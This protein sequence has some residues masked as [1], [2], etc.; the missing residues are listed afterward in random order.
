MDVTANFYPVRKMTSQTTTEKQQQGFFDIGM[1]E[2]FWC[3]GLR[4]PPIN[5]WLAT[6]L[7]QRSH[8]LGGHIEIR[9]SR[10]AL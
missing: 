2:N 3:Y 7:T 4:E 1:P 8:I 9:I 6:M 5:I 10:L